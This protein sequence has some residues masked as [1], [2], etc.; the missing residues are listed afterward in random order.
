[1]RHHADLLDAGVLAGAQGTHPGRPRARRVPVR[2]RQALPPRQR[3]TRDAAALACIEVRDGWEL[4]SFVVTTLGLPFAILFFAWEQRKERDNEEEEQYQLLSD[5]YI[6]FLEGRARPSRPAPAHQRAPLLDPSAASSASACS[7]SSTCSFRCSSAP[8]WWPGS[9]CMGE[10]ERRRWNSWDDY[11]R[12]WCRRE[13]FHNALPLLLRGEDPEFQDYIRRVADEE[14]GAIIIPTTARSEHTMSDS[15]VIVGAARTPMGGF[16]GD[17]SAARRA[18]PRRRRDQ[19]RRRARRHPG[20]RRRR[21][22][23]RQLPDGRPGP[24]AGAPGRVQGAACPRAPAPS[25][26]PRCAAPA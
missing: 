1:M 4:A 2:A 20:R 22:A 23:V 13:D 19:G 14:R 25:R 12:E 11:M 7:S 24:G 16:Q 9:P 10:T 8:T 6:D 21:S 3:R 17:F 18:R 5:A 15:I 26:C